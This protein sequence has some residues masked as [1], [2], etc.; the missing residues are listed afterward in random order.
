MNLKLLCLGL[1]LSLVSVKSY[2]QV[3]FGQP[4]KIGKDWKFSLGDIKDG[5]SVSLNDSRWQSVDVPHDW[6]VRGQ[7]SPS[8][9]SCTGY[10]PGGIGWYRKTINVPQDKDGQKVYLYFEGVY[11]RSEVYINGQLLGKRPNGYVSF[12]YDATPYVKYGYCCSC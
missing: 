4:E 5:Q 6:S 7:Y 8:L 1:I 3:S 11:N 10:L 2:S 9:A 12:M